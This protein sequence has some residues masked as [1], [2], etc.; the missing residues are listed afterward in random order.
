MFALDITG[1]WLMLLAF[2]KNWLRTLARTKGKRAAAPS[3][4]TLVLESLEERVM[5]A[6]V[7]WTGVGGN[8]L[9]STAGNWTNN[10]VP[11]TG[12]DVQITGHVSAGQTVR[13][14]G[15]TGTLHSL[16]VTKSLTV[17]GGTLDAGTSFSV[18]GG[19][20]NFDGGT[21]AGTVQLTD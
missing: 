8:L 16:Q 18:V 6:V 19:A 13:Y 11:A 4:H 12:D 17:A 2:G 14:T 20:L 21:I 10:H 5:P 7:Q 9:W 1:D 15:G 3:R